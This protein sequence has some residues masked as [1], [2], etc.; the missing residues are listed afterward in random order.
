MLIAPLVT[1]RIPILNA[2]LVIVTLKVPKQ[3][4]VLEES[5]YVLVLT[6]MLEILA[7]LVRQ[8]LLIIQIGNVFYTFTPT[9]APA[10][11][12]QIGVGPKHGV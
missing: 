7:T 10:G 1:T 4:V 2:W 9:R 8:L 3:K 11:F 6:I 5:G 12:F